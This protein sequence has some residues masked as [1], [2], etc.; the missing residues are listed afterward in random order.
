MK[1]PPRRGDV[2]WVNLDPVVGTEIKKTRPAVVVSNDSCNRFS[3]R[4]V[5]LPI[6]SNVHSLYPGEALVDVKGK[7]GRALG[8]QIRSVDKAGL[9]SRAA[10]LTADEMARIDEAL[11]ITLALSI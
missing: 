6:T 7:P 5:V 2:Y 10:T 11:A 9:K 8:D 4:V 1:R 3:T